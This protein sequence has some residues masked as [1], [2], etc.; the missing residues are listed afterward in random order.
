M[1]ISIVTAFFDIGRG[2]WAKRANTPA[3]LARGT[4]EYFV[5]VGCMCR[6]ENEIVVFTQS[7]FADRIAVARAKLGF[8]NQSRIVCKDGLFE[9]HAADLD[10]ITRVM[11]MPGFLVDITH[12]HCPEYW[13]PR[14]VLI[15]YLKSFFACEAIERGLAAREFLA[16]V[17][18]GYCRD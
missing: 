1:A 9:E 3:W 2:G 6:L 17:D 10:K 13:E 16:W 18:F 7:K 11:N 14:Y 12:P 8:S 15:N 5:C 4:E